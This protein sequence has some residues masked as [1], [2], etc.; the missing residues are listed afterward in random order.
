M[1]ACSATQWTSES[2]QAGASVIFHYFSAQYF[3]L[4]VCWEHAAY[5]HAVGRDL[6]PGYQPTRPNTTESAAHVRTQSALWM[7]QQ[8]PIP[9]SCANY[10][11]RA[12]VV[13]CLLPS[14]ALRHCNPHLCKKHVL[15]AAQNAMDLARSDGAENPKGSRSLWIPAKIYRIISSNLGQLQ[16]AVRCI[17]LRQENG[18]GRPLAVVRASVHPPGTPRPKPFG[19]VYFKILLQIKKKINLQVIRQHEYKHKVS[20]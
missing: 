10:P 17:R 4:S 8:R 14:A 2:L 16:T 9:W 5:K 7:A 3:F 1:K 15:S 6:L 11:F 20:I 19:V 12:L 18:H 13:G